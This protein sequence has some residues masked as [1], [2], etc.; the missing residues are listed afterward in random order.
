MRVVWGFAE[1]ALEQF[2]PSNGDFELHDPCDVEGHHTSCQH[3]IVS[4][5]KFVNRPLGPADV[6]KGR[7]LVARE[8]KFVELVGGVL[9]V[10]L[11]K[12]AHEARTSQLSLCHGSRRGSQ[13]RFISVAYV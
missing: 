5:P 7:V 4:L 9:N 10:V 12:P 1:L 8:S 11:K 2:G 13:C 6:S 3:G